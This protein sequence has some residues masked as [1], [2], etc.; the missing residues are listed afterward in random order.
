MGVLMRDYSLRAF[1]RFGKQ[2]TMEVLHEDIAPELRSAMEFMEATSCSNVIERTHDRGAKPGVNE[3][4]LAQGRVPLY[5]TKTLT[6]D[7]SKTPGGSAGRGALGSGRA[8]PR[9][10][11][12]RGHIRRLHNGEVIWIPPTVIGQ[13][14][15]GR[16]EKS[17]VVRGRIGANG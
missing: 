16:I 2:R 1:S 17:Y 9:E 10:H 6:I 7:F 11:L 5:E 3:R 13:G 14:N 8:S 12:R 15:A 4:R